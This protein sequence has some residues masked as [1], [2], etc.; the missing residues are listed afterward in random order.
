MFVGEGCKGVSNT[1]PC[2]QY[3]QALY[4]KNY[5]EVRARQFH[6]IP[7]IPSLKFMKMNL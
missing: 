5:Q 4:K 3:P 2:V 1:I 6:R 7:P